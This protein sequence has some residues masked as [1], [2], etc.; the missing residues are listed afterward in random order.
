[1]GICDDENG[2]EPEYPLIDEA[3]GD[4]NE[5]DVNKVKDDDDDELNARTPSPMRG[6]MANG[7][8]KSIA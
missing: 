1:M 3:S 4:D 5:D 2:E 6:L 7:S 8:S